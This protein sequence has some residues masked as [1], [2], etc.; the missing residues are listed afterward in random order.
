AGLRRPGGRAGGPAPRPEHAQERERVG[1]LVE[2]RLPAV[3]PA[4]HVV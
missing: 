1:R 2:Q 3:A 4:E